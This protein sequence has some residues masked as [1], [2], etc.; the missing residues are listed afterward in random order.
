MNILKDIRDILI[1]NKDTEHMLKI[2][3]DWSGVTV[4]LEYDPLKEFHEDC[5]IPIHYC[6]IDEFS[7]IPDNKLREMHKPNDYGMDLNEITL[8]K[9]I[10]EYFE[11]HKTEIAEL[12][13]GYDC[14]NRECQLESERENEEVN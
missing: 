13:N 6:T 10:M 7:Y 9:E 8:M 3:V 11:S 1:K 12:C 14:E 5:I 2:V 4:Y